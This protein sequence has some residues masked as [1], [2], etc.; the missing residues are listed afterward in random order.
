MRL[1]TVLLLYILQILSL[2]RKLEWGEPCRTKD[3]VLLRQNVLTVSRV[4]CTLST[5]LTMM[6]CFLYLFYLTDCTQMCEICSSERQP[7]FFVRQMLPLARTALSL[8]KMTTDANFHSKV[9]LELFYGSFH[10][11]CWSSRLT[12]HCSSLSC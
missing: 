6:F 3:T 11:A 8:E 2:F 12:I 10:S 7:E 4:D 9:L 1:F 5:Q